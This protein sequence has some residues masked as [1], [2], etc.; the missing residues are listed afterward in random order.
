MR[1]IL[2]GNLSPLRQEES[3]PEGKWCDCKLP[4]GQQK[5]PLVGAGLMI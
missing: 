5:S 2:Q 1:E 4:I 3:T